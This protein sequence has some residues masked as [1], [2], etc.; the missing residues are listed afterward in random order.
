MQSASLACDLTLHNSLWAQPQEATRL[1]HRAGFKPCLTSD[2][3]RSHKQCSA[4]AGPQHP[5]RHL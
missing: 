1:L 4:A 2:F 5:Q 3:C